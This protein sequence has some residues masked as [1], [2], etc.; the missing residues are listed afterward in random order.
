MIRLLKKQD[1]D[2]FVA[3]STVFYTMP[4]CAH[5]VPVAHFYNTAEYC[6]TQP[7]DYV[8]LVIEVENTLAGYCSLSRQ[9]LPVRKHAKQSARDK[10]L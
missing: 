7:T 5:S 9:T 3:M 8:V 10:A 6:L 4:A 2:E 1:I